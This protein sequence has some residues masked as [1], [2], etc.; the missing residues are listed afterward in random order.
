M[1]QTLVKRILKCSWVLPICAEPKRHAALLLEGEKIAAV[2]D[3]EQSKL[4]D[5]A[6]NPSVHDYGD[7]V[8]CPGLINLHTHL[9]YSLLPSFEIGKGLLPWTKALMQTV[10][11]WGASDWLTSALQGARKAAGYGTS[12]LVDSS[13]SG[14]AAH[15][16][17]EVGLKGL[18]GLELFGIDE[19]RAENI[20]STWLAK[21]QS[22][23]TSGNAKLDEALQCG[24]VEITVSPHAPYTVCPALWQLANK[25]AAENDRLVL[26]HLAE[27]Q[28]EC[29]WF[30]SNDQEMTDHLR[31][32]FGSFRGAQP[33]DED[34]L[35]WKQSGCS[36][37]EHLDR[38]QLLNAN[39]LSAHA[40]AVNDDDL[41][42][43]GSQG[44]S[45]AHCP[46]S[47]ARL[48]NGYAPLEKMRTT[49]LKLGLGTDSLASCEDLDM[50]AEAR[51]AVALNQA[52]NPDSTY[53]PR[54]A[55]EQ[56]TIEA[57]RCLRKENEIGS[58]APGKRAD[59]AIFQIDDRRQTKGASEQID[60]YELLVGGHCRLRELLID[61][62]SRHSNGHDQLG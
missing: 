19:G 48:R 11:N 39:L 18:I 6:S 36:P 45:V 2:I 3:A 33:F 47:N 58:L 40:V 62:I 1:N 25:W 23:I 9:D 16:L 43:L 42:K 26:T 12:F 34:I 8:I 55:L 22:L 59:L 20:W 37:V 15:A 27:S 41:A 54:Q 28:Q 46:R 24:R 21:Y 13:Y 30:V 50:L 57:A 7:A 44:V 35:S 17:A 49:G 32:A 5:D 60:P 4:S 10:V 51:F 29:R 52:V 31:F 14:S 61:G 38:H 56:I 53:G